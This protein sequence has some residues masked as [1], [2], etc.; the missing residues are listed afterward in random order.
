MILLLA[1]SGTYQ[2]PNF[3]MFHAR[4]QSIVSDIHGTLKADAITS[5]PIRVVVG[6]DALPRTTSCISEFF[7][8][9][10]GRILHIGP[11][12]IF[13]GYRKAIVVGSNARISRSVQSIGTS[14]VIKI[15]RI[16]IRRRFIKR[17]RV[18]YA[19]GC[20]RGCHRW[21]R[22]GGGRG[23]SVG[24]PRTRCQCGKLCGLERDRKRRCRCGFCR[25]RCIERVFGTEQFDH[26]KGWQRIHPMNGS[27]V[28]PG[29]R[30]ARGRHHGQPQGSKPDCAELH[31]K[32]NQRFMADYGKKVC[33][34]PVNIEREDCTVSVVLV[35]SLFYRVLPCSVSC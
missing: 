34:I 8:I 35:R 12:I 18:R 7:P 27:N 4:G 29:T 20:S 11:S 33:L 26:V 16:G 9:K 22:K 15:P 23:R 6:Q 17:V 13:K 19:R 2:R 32:G 24:G 5:I 3:V 25:C 30:H 1:K 21:N 31:D 10:V 28:T 14:V